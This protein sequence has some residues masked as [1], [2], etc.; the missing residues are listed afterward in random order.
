[1]RGLDAEEHLV[2][3]ALDLDRHPPE[4]R[5]VILL[6]QLEKR[7]AHL[8]GRRELRNTEGNVRTLRETHLHLDEGR[9]CARFVVPCHGSIV[10]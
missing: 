3:H 1:V 5:R 2:G 4:A 10:A 6:R 7:G 8:L 9:A